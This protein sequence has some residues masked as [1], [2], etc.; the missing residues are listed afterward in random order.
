ME[1]RKFTNIDRI[2]EVADVFVVF[3][4]SETAI[5]FEKVHEHTKSDTAPAIS[6][7]N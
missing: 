3:G 4:S 6:D 7:K 1:A 5:D 2:T